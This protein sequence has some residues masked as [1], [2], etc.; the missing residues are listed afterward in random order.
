[1]IIHHL[2]NATFVIESGENCI[3]VDP[4]LGPQG[5]LPPFAR[6]KHKALRN[7][8]VELPDTADTILDKVNFNLL[9]HS[10]KWG[11]EALT[12]TD[13]LDAEGRAFLKEKQITRV[14]IMGLATDYCVK[15]T[16]LDAIE[17]GFETFLIADGCR[18]VDLHP[19]DIKH[20]IEEMKEAGVSVIESECL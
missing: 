14:Y 5:P 20:A 6:F 13:H 15:F 12:H 7:P 2:R 11:I 3:L 18:G 4:M 16:A 19:G 17:L 8:T 1:M 10:Q 9:T